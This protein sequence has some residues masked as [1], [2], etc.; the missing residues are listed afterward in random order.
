MK[1]VALLAALLIVVG[2][3]VALES[4]DDSR[5][6]EPFALG[7]VRLVSVESCAELLDW[8]QESAS[9][10]DVQSLGGFAPGMGLADDMVSLDAA[11]TAGGAERSA[12]PSA[13]AAP[14]ESPVTS[15]AGGVGGDGD[16]FSGT[17]VQE[18]DVDEPDTVKTNGEVIVRASYDHLDIV[19]IGDGE[20]ELLSTVDLEEGGTEILL[21]DDRVLALTN[22]WRERGGPEPAARG[23]ADE[24]IGIMPVYGEPAVVLTAIDIS[25]PS[26]P[27]VVET[28]E[29]DGSYRSA[30]VVGS[31]VRLVLTASPQLPP[32]D[33]IVYQSGDPAEVEARLEE[34][35]D[36]AVSSMT[37][38]DWVP[39]IDGEQGVACDD[40]SRPTEPA[41]FAT[42]TVIT[43]DLQGE[44]DVLDED[45][46]VADTSTIYA[47]TDRLYVTTSQWAQTFAPEGGG[48]PSTQLHA[49]DITDPGETTYVGSGSVPGFLLNQ[50][51]L[52]ERG[53]FLRVATTQQPPWDPA[54]PEQQQAATSSS[55]AVLAERDGQ[56]VE[57]GRLDGLG[58]TE[59]IQAVRF[60]DDVAYVVTFRR[61][62]PLFVIDLAD[63]T[64]PTVSGE[65]KVPG[66]SAYLHPIDDGRVLGVGQDADDE[67]RTR[68]TQVSTFDV[69]DAANPSRTDSV[70]IE[71]S[72]SPV[73]YDHRA[74]LWW[75]STRT[76]L[77]PIEVY[78]DVVVSEPMIDCPPNADCVAPSSPPPAQPPFMGVVAFDVDDDGQIDERGRVTHQGRGI[79][80]NGW[81]PVQRSVVAGDAL[82]TISDAG[83]LKS[84]LRS[85]DDSGFVQFPVPDFAQRG[86]GG[87][88]PMPMPVEPMPM[89]VEPDGG[90]GG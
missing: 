70:T 20:P 72:S 46:V 31:T 76:A 81:Y 33:P 82:Y 4:G 66:Y 5:P 35:K 41:G 26:S 53:G 88:E 54:Q 24:R 59:T 7:Q 9:A 12:S 30:R 63:P 58:P 25:D 44:L 45:A 39:S 79:D 15:V 60:L 65:V 48:A 32:I 3:A 80:P 29:I 10:I 47:S 57:V 90:A 6:R 14:A 84:D 49:F 75:A 77:V 89:P 21:G 2:A 78:Q 13:E 34:W 86:G 28:M 16:E 18:E 83:I 67:G 8:Y 69:S 68:G 73:E 87:V 37:L 42:T 74:F 27:D 71:L 38:D 56:L 11:E 23:A 17:N 19:G 43:L 85:L 62:D 51:S 40:V 52:S 55:M 36:E 50:F 22:V 1:L 64:N 61:T